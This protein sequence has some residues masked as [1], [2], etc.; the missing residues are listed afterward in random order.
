MT[1][2]SRFILAGCHEDGVVVPVD[3]DH[4]EGECIQQV[5]VGLR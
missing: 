1:R 5:K 4:G 2:R 3:G